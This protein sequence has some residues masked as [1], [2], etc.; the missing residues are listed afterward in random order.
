MFLISGYQNRI[1][2]FKSL[3]NTRCFHF[4][5]IVNSVFELKETNIR[6]RNQWRIYNKSFHVDEMLS[7]VGNETWD[8]KISLNS[9]HGD[10]GAFEFCIV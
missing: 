2:L 9:D 4:I 7:S 5:K 6:R 3:Y 10:C 1:F 8:G